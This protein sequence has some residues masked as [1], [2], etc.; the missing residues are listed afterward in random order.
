MLLERASVLEIT[1]PAKAGIIVST[2]PRANSRRWWLIPSSAML[3]QQFTGWSAYFLSA[4]MQLP[5]LIR[6]ATSKRTPLFNGALDCRLFEYKMVEGG[7]RK[8]TQRKLEGD[9]T[10]YLNVLTAKL[11]SRLRSRS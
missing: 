6:L 8:K 3:K 11:P 2:D 4:D 10:R 1:A 7:M 5:K 9:A